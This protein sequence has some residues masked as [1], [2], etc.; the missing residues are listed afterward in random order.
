ME[1]WI[2]RCA[3]ETSGWGYDR[4]DGALSNLG[5]QVSDQTVLFLIQLRHG[6][7]RLPD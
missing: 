5:H 3:Q 4:I 7:C 2:V 6:A 1:T